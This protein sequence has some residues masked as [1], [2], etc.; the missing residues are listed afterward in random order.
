MIHV[1][2]RTCGTSCS[3]R[4]LLAPA[5]ACHFMRTP[6]MWI[7][8]ARIACPGSWIT[9]PLPAGC[10]HSRHAAVCTVLAAFLPLVGASV[11]DDALPVGAPVLA[12]GLVHR[13]LS[14]LALP[15]ASRVAG[16]CPL[17]FCPARGAEA[18]VPLG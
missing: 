13:S 17:L 1:S 4:C 2:G 7:P 12:S 14:A 8:F 9:F 3:L 18:A 15:P 6:L 11:A 16:R 5:S 10:L